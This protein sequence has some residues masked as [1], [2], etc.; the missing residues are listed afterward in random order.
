[1]ALRAVA[2][3]ARRLTKGKWDLDEA[4]QACKEAIL[5]QDLRRAVLSGRQPGTQPRWRKVEI[6]PVS[7]TKQGFKLQVV[8]HEETRAHTSNHSYH[9]GEAERTVTQLLEE[10]FG[11]WR[12]EDGSEG[13]VTQV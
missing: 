7:L 13:I 3:Q 12:I 1:M 11:H 8:K 9:S 5:R 4:R 10:G 6:W 2:K